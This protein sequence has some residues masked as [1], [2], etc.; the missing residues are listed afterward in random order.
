MRQLSENMVRNIG[1]IGNT[2]LYNHAHSGTKI[3]IEKYLATVASAI[4]MVGDASA[5]PLDAR[6]QFVA[7]LRQAYGRSALI[8]SHGLGLGECWTI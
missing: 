2:Q 4:H 7:N 5:M 3:L 1:G 8:L 6:E